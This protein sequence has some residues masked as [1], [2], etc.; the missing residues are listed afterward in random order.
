MVGRLM[1]AVEVYEHSARLGAERL[2]FR[3]RLA[4]LTALRVYGAI[5]RRVLS[6]GT[7]AW[8]ERVTVGK[9]EKLAYLVPSLV[10]AS[11]SGLR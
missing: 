10:E 8:D 6:R 11:R 4:V 5:G 9:L 3:S 1:K 2:P 7:S